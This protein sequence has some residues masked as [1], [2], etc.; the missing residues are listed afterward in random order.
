[1][2]RRRDDELRLE[3]IGRGLGGWL[4]G[5]GLLRLHLVVFAVGAVGILL[6]NL[7]RSPGDLWAAEALRLWAII[8][9][10]HAAAL[11]TGWST[12]RAVR[13]HRLPTTG[14]AASGGPNAV[15]PAPIVSP[16]AR[17]SAN[18]VGGNGHAPVYPES[19]GVSGPP[20][21]LVALPARGRFSPPPSEPPPV[22]FA[23]L[24]KGAAGAA[25]SK[26]RALAAGGAAAGRAG[27]TRLSEAT[28]TG[29]TAISTWLDGTEEVPAAGRP[30]GAPPSMVSPYQHAE[31]RVPVPPGWPDP[32]AVP[33]VSPGWEAVV[34]PPAGADASANAAAGWPA[35]PTAAPNAAA[36]HHPPPPPGW[37]AAAVS[38]G[39]GNPGEPPKAATEWTR[40]E[41]AAAAW[42]ARRD[43]EEPETGPVPDGGVPPAAPRPGGTAAP[44][45]P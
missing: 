31:A 27:W 4:I 17:W 22:G 29:K 24:S 20:P 5:L 19:I 21:E 3:E 23:D 8:L 44:P 10:C 9:G 30:P 1:M 45:R 11:L 6:L 43:S 34:Q 12:W 33:D 36:P 14:T 13:P 32:P 15:A 25:T 28:R 7:Y 2:V 37:T 18:G 41:A 42:F 39:S 16:A 38:G 26:L 35:P 40:M